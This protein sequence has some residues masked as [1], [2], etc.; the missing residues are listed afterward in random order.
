MLLV[1]FGSLNPLHAPATGN[2]DDA[3][4]QKLKISWFGCVFIVVIVVQDARFFCKRSAFVWQTL[5]L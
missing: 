3:V 5:A 2:Y 4:A 1:R